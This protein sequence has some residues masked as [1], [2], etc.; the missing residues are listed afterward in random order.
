M[1]WA[2][3]ALV[4]SS[5]LFTQVN[6]AP[7]HIDLEAPSQIYREH[8]ARYSNNKDVD[9][10]AIAKA[11]SWGNRLA[12][13][14]EHENA[15]RDSTR[16]LRLTSANTR[17]G[18]PIDSPSIYSEQTVAAELETF[19]SEIAPLILEVLNGEAFPEQLPLPDADFIV[20][21]RKI[22]RTYQTA[23]RFK[24]LK[25]WMSYYARAKAQDVR[26]F[27]FFR[28]NHWTSA[29]MAQFS[30]FSSELKEQIREQL[31]ELCLNSGSTALGCQRSV[32]N[33]ESRGQLGQLFE[34]LYAEGERVWN[35]FFVIPTSAIRSD[36]TWRLPEI[37]EIPF[38]TPSIDRFIPYLRD[39][40]QDEFRFNDW[41]L[42]LRFGT[43]P[44][45]PRLKFEPGVVP[46]VDGLGGNNI[47]MDSNQSIEEY[48]SQWTIRHEFGHVLGLPDC[49]HEFYDSNLQAFVN[50]QLDVN[51]LMCS[52]AGNMNE[53]I[54]LELEKAYYQP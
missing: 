14:L 37:A 26:A 23:A 43:F 27:Y 1:L 42:R 19:Q 46:H 22:D 6:A 44:N 50:Y 20:Q 21:A 34:Q 9:H 47:V 45:G 3:S 12:Q 41:G 18:I 52:R 48:E 53:R 15:R 51:D 54:F 32:A 39:N 29:R 25:P 7:V 24:S 35:D 40:I 49:Y 28:E 16:Q 2:V 13:W 36:L 10:P 4:L 5:V 30:T 17:R 11:L 38:N 33:A 8:L 31:R